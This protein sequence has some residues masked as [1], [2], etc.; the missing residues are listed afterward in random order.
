MREGYG[1]YFR[2]SALAE[3]GQRMARLTAPGVGW[4]LSRLQAVTG[5]FLPPLQMGQILAENRGEQAGACFQGSPSLSYLPCRGTRSA[6]LASHIWDSVWK[7][8]SAI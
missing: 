4:G 7:D 6:D 2:D 5:I 8:A 1:L 3:G